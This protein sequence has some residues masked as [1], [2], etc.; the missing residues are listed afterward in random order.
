MSTLIPPLP[1]HEETVVALLDSSTVAG[2]VLTAAVGG[3]VLGVGV[4]LLTVMVGGGAG[5]SSSK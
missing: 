2:R 1:L 4:Y 5:P 3:A